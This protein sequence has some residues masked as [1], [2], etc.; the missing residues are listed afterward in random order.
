[1]IKGE[2]EIA[3][4]LVI[5]SRPS[6]ERNQLRIIRFVFALRISLFVRNDSNDTLYFYFFEPNDQI[7][8]KLSLRRTLILKPILF[9]KNFCNTKL[10]V[11]VENIFNLSQTT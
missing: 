1:M 3:K 6:R 2:N 10:C 11:F 7:T 4:H 8:M 5:P 9:S